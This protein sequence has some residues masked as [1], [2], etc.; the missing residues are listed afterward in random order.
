MK[1][2][3]ML[4]GNLLVNM[5]RFS[6]PIMIADLLQ[7]FF[8]TADTMIVGKFCGQQALAAVGGAAPVLVLFT[9]SLSGISVGANVYLSQAIGRNDTDAVHTGVHTSLFLAVCAGIL[10]ASAGILGARWFLERMAAPP[11]II[12]A[13]VLYLRIYFFA[14]LPIAVFDFC[15]AILRADGDSR[16]PTVYL[17]ISG[18]L[19]VILNLLFVVVFHWDVA[20]VAAASLISQIVC[21]G[22]ILFNLLRRTDRLR[23]YPRDI[24]PQRECARE[25]LRIGLPSALQNSL[26]SVTNIAVQSSINSFGTAAVA[27]NSAANAIEEYVYIALGGFNQAALTFTGQNAGAGKKE[28]IVSILLHALV[29]SGIFGSL[30]GWGGYL[31]GNTFLSLFTSDADV[32]ALG[33]LRLRNVTRWLF[34]NGVLECF[35]ASIRGMGVSL[36]PTI[37]TMT[38]IAGFRLLYIATW[39]QTHHTLAELYLCFPFSWLITSAAQAVLW[40]IVRRKNGFS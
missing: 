36:M 5:I 22:M 37:V 1:K 17:G 16:N 40:F 10:S 15:A 25:I 13:S 7:I 9:W 38:G 4:E 21:A 23:L 11:E 12:D 14:A 6:L 27:A 29:L 31:G 32:I 20:G 19:N 24:R 35:V 34:L 2:T 26:Y 28:R 33:T 39:F 18:A 3:D 30:I 8:N